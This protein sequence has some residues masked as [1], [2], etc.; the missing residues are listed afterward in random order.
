MGGKWKKLSPTF[1]KVVA[2][3][4]TYFNMDVKATRLN[5]YRCDGGRLAVAHPWR[6][7]SDRRP[8]C[9]HRRQGDCDP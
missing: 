8:W 6:S 7:L 9:H 4:R 5:W 3:M 1:E 2:K